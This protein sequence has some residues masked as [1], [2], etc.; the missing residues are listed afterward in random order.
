[1]EKS[2]SKYLNE[3][4][5]SSLDEIDST[6]RVTMSI[7]AVIR[8]IDKEFSLSANYPKSHGELFLWIREHYPG[9]L[10]LHVE[11]A[12]GS[13][14]DLCTDGCFAIYMN[15][16]YYIMFLDEIL[17][18]PDADD[19]ASILQ[20]NLFVVLTSLEMQVAPVQEARLGSSRHVSNYRHFYFKLENVKESP[21]L[22][23]HENFMMNIFENYRNGLPPF[24]EY[25]DL[26][27]H[28]KQMRVVCRT[29]G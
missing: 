29:D 16:E 14:Q 23:L 19:K 17:R 12:A 3:M 25:L 6:L 26:M 21:S 22:I 9:V 18:K 13:R 10:L 7:S 4:L 24:K 20:Q 1:M 11:R 27:Y 28:K 8:A 5:R 15:Y 2:L